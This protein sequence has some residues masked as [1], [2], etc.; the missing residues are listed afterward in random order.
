MSET[1]RIYRLGFEDGKR[2]VLSSPSW[3]HPVRCRK[4]VNYHESGG[5]CDFLAADSGWDVQMEPDDYCS[6]GS[7]EWDG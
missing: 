7:K 6:Y 3:V 1:E 2:A 4:C 5:F